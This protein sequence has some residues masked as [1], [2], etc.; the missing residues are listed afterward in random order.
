MSH[1][2][3]G[4][5][6]RRLGGERKFRDEGRGD[7]RYL[8]SVWTRSEE[9]SRLFGFQACCGSEGKTGAEPE[10]LRFSLG[11]D[12]EGVDRIVLDQYK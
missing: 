4:K 10:M 2:E 6:T 3:R 7:L 8:G 11:E 1:Q 9:R 12:Q 5:G